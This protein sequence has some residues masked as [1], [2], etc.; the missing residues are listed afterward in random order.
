L[1]SRQFVIGIRRRG[2]QVIDAAKHEPVTTLSSPV[3]QGFAFGGAVAWSAGSASTLPA[4]KAL[5]DTAQAHGLLRK[6]LSRLKNSGQNCRR[7]LSSGLNLVSLMSEKSQLWTPS[8]R[9]A[10]SSVQLVMLTPNLTARGGTA[11]FAATS[12][13]RIVV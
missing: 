1:L 12:K 5:L 3:T 8:A 7:Y 9:S 6:L 11:F 13:A 4:T 10:G 2:V